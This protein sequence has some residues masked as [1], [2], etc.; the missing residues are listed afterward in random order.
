MSVEPSFANLNKIQS[1]NQYDRPHRH[2]IDI[3][4]GGTIPRTVQNSA[5]LSK[6]NSIVP[7]IVPDS[8][9]IKLD[10]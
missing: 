9:P 1:L 2:T 7:F 4:T 5:D 10:V 8:E 3:Q 6:C